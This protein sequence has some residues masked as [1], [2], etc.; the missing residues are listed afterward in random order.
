MFVALRSRGPVLRQSLWLINRN[1]EGLLNRTEHEP[2][3]VLLQLGGAPGNK[4]HVRDEVKPVKA[5]WEDQDKQDRKC[6]RQN[7]P[8]HRQ[9]QPHA[10]PAHGQDFREQTNGEEKDS[11]ETR[12]H[13]IADAGWLTAAE[14]GQGQSYHA[15]QDKHHQRPQKDA[16][17]RSPLG[18]DEVRVEQRRTEQ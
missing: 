6:R 15:Q 10:E 13:K 14:R 18:F 4:K 2:A 17:Q 9:G 12:L 1:G 8:F 3:K 7:R 5:G 11:Q 16:A